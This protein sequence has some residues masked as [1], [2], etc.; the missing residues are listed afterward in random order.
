M[1]LR[2][3]PNPFGIFYARRKLKKLEDHFNRKILAAEQDGDFDWAGDCKIDSSMAT[4]D[5]RE[6]CYKRD[7]DKLLKQAR[8]FGLSLHA[9]TYPRGTCTHAHPD[10]PGA[11]HP[12]TYRALRGFV[13]ATRKQKSAERREILKAVSPV[14]NSICV[15]IGATATWIVKH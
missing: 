8:R 10:I 12:E 1:L 5:L 15:L 3:P 11:I 6:L 4:A 13:D 9:L 2:I 7:S 14:I